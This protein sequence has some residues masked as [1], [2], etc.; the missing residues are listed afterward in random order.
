MH[1]G[2]PIERVLKL[3]DNQNPVL[4]EVQPLNQELIPRYHS[5]AYL[6]EP[7][8]FSKRT[9]AGRLGRRQV[10][11]L[12]QIGIEAQVGDYYQGGLVTAT[13]SAGTLPI[14]PLHKYVSEG[15]EAQEP[16]QEREARLLLEGLSLCRRTIVWCVKHTPELLA[17][18]RHEQE[19]QHEQLALMF[20]P[21]YTLAAVIEPTV[22]THGPA[23][24]LGQ[25]L[26]LHLSCQS[27]SMS[28]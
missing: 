22:F 9:E 8:S 20:L 5:L 17:S 1:W 18:L 6:G 3:I 16:E 15:L 10:R 26:E 11:H 28:S 24:K 21:A 12:E 23:R 4:P 19:T 14:L 2:N 27:P 7:Q 13:T 25:L